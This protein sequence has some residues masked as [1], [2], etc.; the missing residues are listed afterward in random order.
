M[1]DAQRTPTAV[2][3]LPLFS[4]WVDCAYGGTIVNITKFKDLL[5]LIWDME[6]SIEG[7]KKLEKRKSTKKK[8]ITIN[9]HPRENVDVTKPS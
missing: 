8:T 1:L 3:T 5:F 4:L 6:G 2:C 9:T 7:V